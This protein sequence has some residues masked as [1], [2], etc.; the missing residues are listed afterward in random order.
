MNHL[1]PEVIQKPHPKDSPL[2]G[3]S[4]FS[5][6]FQ[7]DEQLMIAFSQGN[8]SAFTILFDRYRGL[9]FGFFG[10]RVTN[11]QVA[12]ELTQSTFLAV[13]QDSP[14]YCPSGLFRT[15][16]YAIAFRILRTYR[17]ETGVRT[18]MY[19]QQAT[20][21]ARFNAATMDIDVVIRQAVETLNEIDR[22]V[23]LLREF[24]HLNS[25][26]IAELLKLP[27]ETIDFRLSH[28]RSALYNL[29]FDPAAHTPLH[30]RSGFPAA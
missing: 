20:E 27:L 23:L 12:E 11:P 22:E 21:P 30:R 3:L 25:A 13:L 2:E 1:E 14:G 24:E 19:E 15:W 5:A 4:D 28:A 6:C 7:S 26:E 29:L 16:I 10:R 9:L 17:Q 18:L 8:V